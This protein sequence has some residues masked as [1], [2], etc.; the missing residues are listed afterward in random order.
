MPATVPDLANVACTIWQS[1]LSIELTPAADAAALKGH[2]VIGCVQLSGSWS[3]TIQLVCSAGMARASVAAMMQM[4]AADLGDSDINDGLGEL[5]NMVGGSVKNGLP[6]PTVLSPPMV[7]NGEDVTMSMPHSTRIGH[8][9][10]HLGG[11]LL[12]VNLYQAE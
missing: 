11:Q 8:T 12:Q 10:L 1:M 6:A 9:T 2:L 7:V 5:A 4:E 3:G